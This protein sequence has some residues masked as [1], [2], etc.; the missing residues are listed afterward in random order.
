M[1]IT[2]VFPY[3]NSCLY[4]YLAYICE[5]IF[6]FRI[7]IVVTSSYPRDQGVTPNPKF[8]TNSFSDSL[9]SPNFQRKTRAQA[10]LSSR[11]WLSI[12]SRP[13]PRICVG[14]CTR[15]VDMCARAAGVSDHGEFGRSAR[16]KDRIMRTT[17]A[18]EAKRRRMRVLLGT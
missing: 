14:S 6:A 7:F 8:T 12:Q 13:V 5:G 11:S 3:L 1:Y 2:I 9:A 17:M 16:G 15:S 4:S 18:K 10:S